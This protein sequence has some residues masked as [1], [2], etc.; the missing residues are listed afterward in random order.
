[1]GFT[2]IENAAFQLPGAFRRS[3]YFS[4]NLFV[5]PGT[6]IRSGLEYTQGRRE[7]KDGQH[8]WAGRLSFIMQYDF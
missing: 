3:T 8:G 7:N 4:A 6:G 1:M 2:A 5:E